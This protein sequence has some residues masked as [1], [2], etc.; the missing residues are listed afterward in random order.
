MRTL[1]D[2][3]VTFTPLTI[4]TDTSTTSIMS[5]PD[6]G[7]LINV[8]FNCA[9][10]ITAA[11]GIANIIVNAADTAG[12]DGTAAN[13]TFPVTAINL[14]GEVSPD[15]EV[16]LAAGDSLTFIASG[17]GPTLGIINIT[18]VIRR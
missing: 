1:N 3:F 9:E 11:A 13:V 6:E 12:V 18:A 8:I 2:Y 4:K 15:K 7:T 10:A 17:G 16:D 14:G 5:V